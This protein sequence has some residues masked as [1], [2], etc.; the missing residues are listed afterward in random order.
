MNCLK[1]VAALQ[2]L[3]ITALGSSSSTFSL[4][5]PYFW[6]SLSILEVFVPFPVQKPFWDPIKAS[7]M[8]SENSLN[9]ISI[10]GPKTLSMQIVLSVHL[11]YL[12]SPWQDLKSFKLYYLCI[13]ASRYP[14]KNVAKKRSS[15]LILIRLLWALWACRPDNRFLQLLVQNPVWTWIL[16]WI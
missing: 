5:N 12:Y 7:N 8:L 4:L 15:G 9:I 10:P 16:L 13:I 3:R 1:R 11:C 6:I 14:E 2:R